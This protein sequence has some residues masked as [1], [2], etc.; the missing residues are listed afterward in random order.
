MERPVN[1]RLGFEVVPLLPS[2]FYML[3]DFHRPG[4]IMIDSLRLVVSSRHKIDIGLG[5]GVSLTF[6]TEITM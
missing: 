1:R 3:L 4:E 2:S 5:L 6:W